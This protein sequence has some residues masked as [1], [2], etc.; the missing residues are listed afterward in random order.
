MYFWIPPEDERIGREPD[1][2]FN[3]A[4]RKRTMPMGIHLSGP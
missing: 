4:R 2:I 3:E 1:G